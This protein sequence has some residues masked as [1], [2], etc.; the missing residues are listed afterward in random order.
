M[1]RHVDVIVIGA[2]PAG[3]AASAALAEMGLDILTLDEQHRVGGQIYRNVEEAPKAAHALFGPD[4][5]RGL[6]LT[7]RFRK[8]GA[9]Y[10][11]G[12]CV[13]QAESDGTVCYSQNGVSRRVVANYIVA[14]TGAME[15]PMPIPGWTLPGVMG[16]GAANNLAKEAGLTPSGRVVLAGSGP[17]LLLEASLL[18]KKGVNIAAVLE[19]TPSMPSIRALP[20]A[21][22]ALLRADFLLKGAFMLREI[23]R[24]GVPHYKGV[25]GIR[26]LG[27]EAVESVEA[28]CGEKK[29]HLKADML[30]LHFGVIPNTHIFRQMGCRMAWHAGQRCWI[31]A[32]DPWGRTNFENVFAAGDGAGVSGAPAARYK[33]ELAALEIARCLGILS[34]EERNARALPLR[35]ALMHDAW[36]RPFIDAL[37]A[38]RPG[39]FLFTDDTVLCRCENVTVG[40]VHK[41]VKEGVRDLNEIKI[42]TR[43]GMGPCQGR[44]CGPALAEV[45]GAALGVSPHRT[46]QLSVRT[47]L[48]PIPL[49]EIAAMDLSSGPDGGNW[50]LDKK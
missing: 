29:L 23:K 32:C 44:M 35:K 15:R 38:P 14:A 9:R 45:V 36:P 26:A 17:L 6:D 2:G 24:S 28:T 31:P 50:L 46:G 43:C 22:Q 27:E 49:E 12:A 34:E 20:R 8:S 7:Q 30:L 21:P 13:W 33:G 5:T 11:P 40:D 19:T 37:Y 25:T 42:I 4:Y 48:K 18:V 3:L 47:P 10:E 16:A 41:V 1:S 39:Q